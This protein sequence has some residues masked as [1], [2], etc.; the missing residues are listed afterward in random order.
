MEEIGHVDLVGEHLPA[1]FLEE[2]AVGTRG[3][4]PCQR[5]EPVRLTGRDAESKPVPVLQFP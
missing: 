5:E 1:A 2:G 3:Q 4:L